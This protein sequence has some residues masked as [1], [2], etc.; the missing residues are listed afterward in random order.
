MTRR[1][2]RTDD[3]VE[4]LCRSTGSL[5]SS[6]PGGTTTGDAE[7]TLTFLPRGIGLEEP[8][9]AHYQEG[10]QR[11]ERGFAPGA[12]PQIKLLPILLEVFL[13]SDP[14]FEQS[15]WQCSPTRS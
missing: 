8:R 12:P 3:T 6:Y 2:E 7:R 4:G 1:V 11:R 14:T 10:S 5:S 15:R 9:S 13:K